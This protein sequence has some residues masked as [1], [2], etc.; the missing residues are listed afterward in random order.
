MENEMEYTPWL[1]FE[2]CCCM[3]W[4]VVGHM[5]WMISWEYVRAMNCYCAFLLLNTLPRVNEFQCDSLDSI[6]PT[7][8]GGPELI[9]H[10]R[11]RWRIWPQI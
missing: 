2:S 1:I 4:F 10:F 6:R 7:Q 5:E 11:M 8:V 3:I 9:N